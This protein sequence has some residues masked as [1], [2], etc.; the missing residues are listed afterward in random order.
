MDVK[1]LQQIFRRDFKATYSG[2]SISE[3]SV[4]TLK[5]FGCKRASFE[6]WEGVGFG[7]EIIE[8]GYV[9]IRYGLYGDLILVPFDFAERVLVL[10]G[11]PY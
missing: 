11:L 7:S 5:E 9:G 2:F 4:A 8:D 1:K 10:G 3:E 6:V